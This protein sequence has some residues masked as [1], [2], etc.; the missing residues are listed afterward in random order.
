MARLLLSFALC[1]VLLGCQ[2]EYEPVTLL[3]TPRVLALE[4]D[5][6][7]A[8]WDEEVR[9]RART[10]VPEAAGAQAARWSFCPLSLG[11][12]AAYR[13]V[14]PACV[15]A[16]IPDESG[17]VSFVPS[18]LA[19]A[20]L[21]ALNPDASDGGLPPLGAGDAARSGPLPTVLFYELGAPDQSSGPTLL[22]LSLWPGPPPS[23]NQ[24]PR[25]ERFAAAD[26]TVA[27]GGEVDLQ[28][29]VDPGSIDLFSAPDGEVVDETPI[30]HWFSTQGRFAFERTEGLS[31]DNTWRYEKIE[32]PPSEVDV[33]A[34]VRD[35]RGAQT[36]AGPLTLGVTP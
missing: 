36:V 30:V 25:V 18:Q 20:C 35:G 14:D 9:V 2:E 16:L 26:A 34:V 8:T 23:R 6:W 27:V 17:E 24:S 15:T 7:E 22:Q 13:C 21:G 5:P 11:P 29:E 10:Y 1:S 31:G 19:L 32:S 4:A 28:I 33:Y 12:F 3:S